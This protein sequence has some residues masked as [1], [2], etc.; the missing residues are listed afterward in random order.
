MEDVLLLHI[1]GKY[2]CLNLIFIYIFLLSFYFRCVLH[3][4][5]GFTRRIVK[6][7][8]DGEAL[9]EIFCKSH[10]SS[11]SDPVKPNKIKR[12]ASISS[13]VVVETNSIE[14]AFIPTTNKGRNSS[15]SRLS[16]SS[17]LNL[18]SLSMSHMNRFDYH[19]IATTNPPSSSFG[20]R[21][22]KST[23]T[24]K[25]DSNSVN[26]DENRYPIRSLSEW[27]GQSEGEALDLDHF[28]NVIS[29]M[30]PEDHPSNWVDFISSSLVR[31]NNY[32][33]KEDPVY[34]MPCLGTHDDM[35]KLTHSTSENLASLGSERE[36][37]YI[38]D[39]TK[40]TQFLASVYNMTV[41]LSSDK[42]IRSS[43][44]DLTNDNPELFESKEDNNIEFDTSNKSKHNASLLDESAFFIKEIGESEEEVVQIDKN[45]DSG[46]SKLTVMFDGDIRMSCDFETKIID[47]EDNSKIDEEEKNKCFSLQD[48]ENDL[49][50]NDEYLIAGSNIKEL[51]N[52]N[53]NKSAIINLESFEIKNSSEEV[54]LSDRRIISQDEDDMISRMIRSDQTAHKLLTDVLEGKLNKLLGNDMKNLSFTKQDMCK[55]WD[56]IE[57]TYSR[58]RIWRKVASNMVKGMR[59][60]KSDFNTAVFDSVPASWV[61]NADGRPKAP[62]DEDVAHEDEDKDQEDTVCMCCFDGTS[63]EGNRILFC[64]GCNSA[65]HQACYGVTEIPEEDFFCERC[66]GI[67]AIVYD[68]DFETSPESLLNVRD[69]IKCCLCPLY[70]GG[71]KATTDGRW[72]HLCCAA[73]SGNA[74]IHDMNEMSPI[75]ITTVNLQQPRETIHNFNSITTTKSGRPVKA[76]IDSINSVIPLDD[77]IMADSCV[78]CNIYGGYLVSCSH[79][80]KDVPLCIPIQSPSKTPVSTNSNDANECPIE[81][82][83]ITTDECSSNSTNSMEI[84]IIK[85]IVSSDNIIESS[86]NVD[87]P[88]IYDPVSV[89]DTENNI[90]NVNRKCGVVFHPLCAWFKGMYMDSTITD[91]TFQGSDRDGIYPSG[92]KFKFCCSD[93]CPE[94]N[95]NSIIRA[96]QLA[97]RVKY[98]IHE[99]DLDLI[100]GQS[101]TRKHKKK[102][103]S[104]FGVGEGTRIG[105]GVHVK[106]LKPD[107]YTN[108][109]CSMCLIPIEQNLTQ[110]HTLECLTCKIVVHKKC[111]YLS[112]LGGD[113]D[114]IN[115]DENQIVENW[116][117]DT[118]CFQLSEGV[119][120][121][122]CPRLGGTFKQTN[123]NK[124]C[125]VYCS[126]NSP[127]TILFGSHGVV[128]IR[129]LPKESKKQKC[130]VC[131]RKEGS[132]FK[133]SI[134]GC[135]SWFHP[136]CG[137][138][139]GKAYRILKK[140]KHWESY[141]F[142]HIPDGIEKHPSGY[143]VNGYELSSLR[144]SL[145]NARSILDMV[146]RREKMKR[147]INKTEGEF[148]QKLIP[149]L[150]NRAKGDVS[151]ED[152]NSDLDEK[153]QL[154][155]DVE[156][157]LEV[158]KLIDVND[159]D[160]SNAN[161]KTKVVHEIVTYEKGEEIEI[162]INGELCKISS[163]F[164]K[165]NN[166]RNNLKIK[167]ILLAGLLI[168]KK[169]TNVEGGK[170]RFVKNL[171]DA[172]IKQMDSL[173]K[174]GNSIFVSK[175]AQEDF[176]KK[177]GLLLLKNMKLK[178]N[179]IIK[180]M[181]PFEIYP[182]FS[183]ISDEIKPKVKKN[184]LIENKNNDKNTL[185]NRKRGRSNSDIGFDDNL[186]N[187]KNES[188]FLQTQLEAYE[189]ASKRQQPTCD[190]SIIN[191]IANLYSDNKDGY[192]HI[193]T[194]LGLGYQQS[195]SNDQDTI[196]D[197]NVN[198]Y[199]SANSDWNIY[200]NLTSPSLER[201][202]FKILDEIEKTEVP[203][204]EFSNKKRSSIRV[205]KNNSN[206]G[207]DNDID[208]ETRLLIR[209]FQEVPLEEMPDY[210]NYVRR[211]LS[212]ES[213]KLKL[214]AHKYF[215]MSLF[216]KDFY[217]LLNNGR[218]VTPI[219]SQLWKDSKKL[220]ELFEELKVETL[221]PGNIQPIDSSLKILRLKSKDTSVRSDGIISECII[222]SDTV[223]DLLKYYFFD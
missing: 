96:E 157:F 1:L 27:P 32:I 143:W 135:S 83:I 147:L 159:D 16:S 101:K 24:G 166:I 201:R 69:M 87:I 161:K 51:E 150:L 55:N 155:M 213:L 171:K 104:G 142:H 111:N 41:K 30:H 106:D 72:V 134:P 158:P 66:K 169:E 18:E 127:G 144:H 117:C 91:S 110:L 203:N 160:I 128:E 132:C 175:F 105:M 170:Q 54:Y 176:N 215:S 208:S 107:I 154:D 173:A 211:V 60:Q 156:S 62:T 44:N 204:E 140:K 47:D 167:N 34:C 29:M 216:S 148:F 162:V 76:S 63:V 210:N 164:T 68:E 141:C 151:L 185:N 81:S 77:S 15:G 95:S 149:R 78:F 56:Y 136:L 200:P 209:D 4:P 120:C 109:Y 70:H 130:V 64:D 190:T 67:Q 5:K 126:R 168:S 186:F 61:I 19:R 122:L 39:L 8:E 14:E 43:S 133:C 214:H 80:D 125:H 139:S 71:M 17:L 46:Y 221:N 86:V 163:S 219:N 218:S 9:W 45:A 222:C 2:I 113:K 53:K 152:N 103:S 11:V 42:C 165:G 145:D 205:K 25:E 195:Q 100:P 93:H 6:N 3:E 58:Q 12:P 177:I 89:E 118:C 129:S 7:P 115:Y 194:T 114:D 99:S 196:D 92:I 85:T 131:N 31:P 74:I 174:N 183:L 124:W 223:C 94:A 22:N 26:V 97:L 65:I 198:C 179:E 10:A 116:Q 199:A 28:W 52:K 182:D 217:E 102:K 178:E 212:F 20:I 146:N 181:L 21:I 48:N 207:D 84:P 23:T 57:S 38:F 82:T 75:D 37:G 121:A 73:W 192:D 79:E 184:K 153:D 59:D 188:K 220:S 193:M 180:E 137:E 202:I 35:E 197:I 98:H 123:D 49:K 36:Q 206:N 13:Q 90:P 50:W 138:R 187:N 112:G 88:N 189:K 172:S 191:S 119:K 33:T 108:E 40:R